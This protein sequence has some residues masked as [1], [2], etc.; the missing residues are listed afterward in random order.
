M[1]SSAR[2]ARTAS[3][4]SAL[5]KYLRAWDLAKIVISSDLKGRHGRPF[6]E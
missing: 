4:E 5:K 2:L 3:D 1:S 6:N